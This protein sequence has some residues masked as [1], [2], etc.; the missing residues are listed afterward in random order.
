M[1][2]VNP[3][4]ISGIN[5]ITTGSGSDN[6]LTIHT[7]DA[8]STERVRINSSGDVIVGSGI[9]VSP[10]GD[11]F[12][13]GVTTATTFVGALT[14]NVTGNATGL[15]GTPNISAGT[16]SGSTGTFTGDVDIADKIVHTGDTN[17]AMRFP[18]AD[19]ISF[20]GGGNTRL[21]ID[22]SGRVLVGGLTSDS[23]T[24]SMII[25]GNSSTGA[26][27]Q[28]VLNMDIGTTSIS[29]GT[30]VGVIRFGATGDR[31]GADIKAEGAGTWS[32]DSSHPTDLIFATNASG[33]ASTPTERLRITSNGDVGIGYDS[34]TVKLHI[35][36]ASSGFSGTYDNRYHC[37]IEDDGEGYVGFYM[38][39]NG[40]AGL[41][42]A[43]TTGV[44]GYIDYYYAADEMH[45]GATSSQRFFTAGTERIRVHSAGTVNI[46]AGVTLGEAVT[47]TAASNTLDD[48]EEGDW[49]PTFE[50]G[51]GS[52][53]VNAYSVQYGKYVK[54]GKMVYVEGLLRANVTNNSNGTY[55]IGGLPFTVTN[56]PNST[57]I[58]HAKEQSSWTVAPHHF[59]CMNNTTKA[60]ARGGIDVGDSAYTNANSSGF[61]SGSTN[62]NRVY[63]AG[64]YRVEGG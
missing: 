16:I 50:S 42:F 7:S 31:R 48:Y 1:T 24:T 62:N 8:S 54:I 56:T 63:L 15:S 20:E 41:R 40:Y 60:R 39:N 32:A 17:T 52:I 61:N 46:P 13:T 21:K 51:S 57:G 36:E 43:D 23:R 25:S 2:V 64:W 6:L 14:G 44:E 22:S 30:S 3:K 26:T 47:S 55:D 49:T 29:D 35:R 9:T 5:S 45:Y 12:T 27:G 4:S 11:I 33:S 38:P 28:A 59:S 18:A 19:E 10:D 37:I 34:P 53:T 58:I